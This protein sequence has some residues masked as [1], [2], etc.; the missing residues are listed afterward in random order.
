V[1]VLNESINKEILISPECFME[2]NKLESK[3]LISNNVIES[4]GKYMVAANALIS[5]FEL[6]I[7]SM[8]VK[9]NIKLFLHP[10]GEFFSHIS[11][12][13][14]K[15]EIPLLL[16]EEQLTLINNLRELSKRKKEEDISSYKEQFNKE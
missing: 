15:F 14:K 12:N 6:V 7:I 10:S 9:K 16:T 1:T 4:K 8:I 11:L 13:D 5:H 3:Y 2:Q